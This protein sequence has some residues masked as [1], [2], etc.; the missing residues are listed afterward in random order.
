M[1][2]FEH[3]LLDLYRRILDEGEDR[4]D[5]T[6]TGTRALFGERLVID[7]TRGFPLVTTKQTS[8]KLIATELLWFL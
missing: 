1:R 5:R 2:T 6:G 3:D 8:F 4:D 7:L